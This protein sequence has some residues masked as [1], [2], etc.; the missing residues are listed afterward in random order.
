MNYTQARKVLLDNGWQPFVPTGALQ[1]A[2][3][4]KSPCDSRLIDREIAFRKQFRNRGWFETVMCMPSGA[5]LC[6]HQFYDINERG[7]V[8][9]TGSGSYS[10]MPSVVKFYY[11]DIPRRR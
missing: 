2:C 11:E 8:V 6:Y 5:G 3:D 1:L 10:Q 4:G 7:L 9:V